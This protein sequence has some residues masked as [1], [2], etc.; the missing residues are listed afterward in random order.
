MASIIWHR[1][2]SVCRMR[3]DM[4]ALM[5]IQVGLVQQTDKHSPLAQKLMCAACK[6]LFKHSL[7]L[8]CR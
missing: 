7:L 8:I 3:L 4:M 2:Q 6:L 1:T 5:L